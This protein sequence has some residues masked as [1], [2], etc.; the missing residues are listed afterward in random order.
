MD[1]L[2]WTWGAVVDFNQKNWAF[3]TGYFLL[4]EV[5]NSNFYD[6][7]APEH[8]E[9]TAELELR[10]GVFS[11]PGKLRLF[12]WINHGIM[13]G[14]TDALA[15]PLASPGYPDIALTRRV[16]TNYGIVVN[17]EQAITKDVGIFSRASWSPGQAEIVGWTDV[18]ASLSFGSVIKGTS[19]GRP[20]DKVGIAGL[21][22]SL[23]PEAQRYFGAGGLG[24]VIGDGRLNYR[25]ERILET[26]YAYALNQW[27]WL[28]FDFQYIVNP[29]YN[30]DRGP[31]PIYT[32]RL[33]AEF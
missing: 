18:H 3:R 12:G 27:S 33:H 7:H 23:S 28:T 32:V 20:D 9:Y 19:W 22:E 29:A 16:R 10:Y 24:I 8:G 4:P 30:A 15:L 31:V 14:Y 25:K 5:S 6:R 17:A 2:S 21:V 11:Q 26:Y 13:G 1:K